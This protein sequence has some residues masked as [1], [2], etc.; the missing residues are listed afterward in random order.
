MLALHADYVLAQMSRRALLLLEADL[1]LDE[2]PAHENLKVKQTV[3]LKY[4]DI[5]T[6]LIP[7][8]YKCV[9]CTVLM[10]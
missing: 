4:M 8:F 1:N 9:H 7:I 3:A 6:Y 2:K 5:Y 10:I